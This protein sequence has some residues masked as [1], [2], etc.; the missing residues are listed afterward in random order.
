MEWPGYLALRNLGKPFARQLEAVARAIPADPWDL[1]VVIAHESGF[2]PRALN[3]DS[4]ASGLVQWIPSTAVLLGMAS[5]KATASSRV[6]S[7]SAEEQ[8]A[9]V[10]P[11]FW[12]AIGTRN[13]AAW[14]DSVDGRMDIGDLY[15][16]IFAPAWAGRESGVIFEVGTE[17]AEQNP[18][19]QDGDGAITVNS[20]KSHM[21][22]VA[23]EAGSLSRYDDGG[24]PLPKL[25]LP[26]GYRG[27]GSAPKPTEE[28]KGKSGGIGPIVLLALALAVPLLRRGR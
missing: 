17:A 25:R 9:W 18:A 14:P 16:L 2:N 27:S 13:V 5:D 11:T 23:K 15:L 26:E 1:A 20:V 24:G 12:K 4:G 6:L 7:M 22:D 8:L 28:T 10:A 19:L 3:A 21:L